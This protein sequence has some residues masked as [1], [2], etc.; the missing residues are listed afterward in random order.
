MV[1]SSLPIT[2]QDFKTISNSSYINISASYK[3]T[4]YLSLSFG[5]GY[6]KSFN[7]LQYVTAPD[8]NNSDR[9]IFASIDQKTISASL[10]VNLNLSPD[11]TL[12]YWGQPF[13]AT[14]SYFDYKYILDP[15]ADSYRDRF[16]TYS[17]D[18]I[19]DRGENYEVDENRD[20]IMDYDF[21]KN[22]FNFKE[23]LSNLVIRWEYNPGSTV[24]FVWSQTRRGVTDTGK[25]DYF[26]DMGAMFNRDDNFE[27]NNVFLIKLS[28]RFGLK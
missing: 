21:D 23:F 1:S 10:R 8:Y 18:E 13:I 25:L 2:T 19:F 26:Q 27:L 4:N 17:P 11:L 12:Q 16:H 15:M 28:Y 22:D 7:E 3:P 9:Y 5:P 6:S 14:G 20:G 24:Y